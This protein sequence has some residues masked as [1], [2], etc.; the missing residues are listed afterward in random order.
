MLSRSFHELNGGNAERA[1]EISHEIIAV[2]RKLVVTFQPIPGS[3]RRRTLGKL[4]EPAVQC[5]MPS[6]RSASD[7]AW[8]GG[9]N[10]GKLSMPRPARTARKRAASRLHV[11]AGCR[12]ARLRS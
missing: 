12:Q 6:G 2:V 11:Q 3:L 9:G 1:T 7:V 4:P 10:A 8:S 5:H